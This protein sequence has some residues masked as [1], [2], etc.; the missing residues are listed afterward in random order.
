MVSFLDEYFSKLERS[1]RPAPGADY[2]DP[3]VRRR[4]MAHFLLFDHHLL[5]LPWTNLGAVADG[6]FRSNQPTLARLRRMRDK[7]RIKAVLNLRGTSTRPSFRFSERA[8]EELGLD[9][10]VADI[11]GR[12]VNHREALINLLD[13][14][15]KIPTPFVLHCK[16]GADRSGLA[17]ALYRVI[18]LGHPVEEARKELSL[19]Y[20]HASWTSSGICGFFFDHYLAETKKRPMDMETWIREVYDPD[21][22]MRAY[23]ARASG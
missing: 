21:R 15:R 20:L 4:A 5:R 22:F 1:L 16:S 11:R 23:E 13:I 10:H 3:S 18:I 14:F 7:M 8:C 12:R 6:V 17:A 2:G 19:R 9:L